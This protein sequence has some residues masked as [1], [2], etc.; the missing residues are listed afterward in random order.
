[1]QITAQ[2][3]EKTGKKSKSLRY[4]RELPA[5]LFGKNLE[6]IPVTV[7]YE[8][9]AKV[10]SGAG[11]TALIDFNLNE[12]KSKVLIKDVQVDPVTGT[13]VHAGF[14]K[15]NL[16]EKI[17]ADIPVKFIGLENSPILKSGEGIL[18]ELLSEVTIECMPSD[19]PAEFIVDVSGLTQIDQAITVQE[20]EFDRE[21]VHLVD[22]TEE[23]L[24]AKVDYAQMPE[25]E[26]APVDEAAAL[27]SIEATAE[28][29]ETDEDAKEE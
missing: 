29:P 1:M 19:L 9:F 3:R 6:S 17:T 14:Y 21:K 25:E 7:N 18:L 27:E 4:N 20:L 12:D 22:V 16:K 26:E 23:E 8:N 2:V 10:F 5:V 15:V 11:E 24:V 13:F 28:K